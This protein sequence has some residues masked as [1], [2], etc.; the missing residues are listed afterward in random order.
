MLLREQTSCFQDV[1]INR[2]ECPRDRS[3]CC[4]ISRG[5]PARCLSERKWRGTG[6]DSYLNINAPVPPVSMRREVERR[7]VMWHTESCCGLRGAACVENISDANGTDRLCEVMPCVALP[8]AYV[9]RYTFR[10]AAIKCTA[11]YYICQKR[12]HIHCIDVL[13]A[14]P[15]STAHAESACFHEHDDHNGLSRYLKSP[16]VAWFQT[17]HILTACHRFAV[18]GQ[19]SRCIFSM[20]DSLGGDFR[21]LPLFRSCSQATSLNGHSTGAA[22]CACETYLSDES[23]PG[24]RG[25]CYTSGQWLRVTNEVAT[26]VALYRHPILIS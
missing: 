2:S 1:N 20:S 11:R 19:A 25:Q 23:H 18:P 13:S 12:P 3:L 21:F 14:V 26:Q 10:S 24:I 15:L 9:D 8:C 16:A 22:G 17:P 7:L 6:I 4:W 5:L